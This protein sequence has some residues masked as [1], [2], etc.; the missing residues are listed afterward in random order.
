MHYFAKRIITLI[1]LTL[2]ER[3]FTALDFQSD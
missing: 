1:N 2:I 3:E